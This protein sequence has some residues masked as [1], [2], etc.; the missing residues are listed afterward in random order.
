MSLTEHASREMKIV[1]LY[2]KDAD[3]DGMLATAVEELIRKFAEQ[4][5]SGFSAYQT[6]KIF[7]IVARY[8]RLSPLTNNPDEWAD[9]SGNMGN[10]ACWQSCRQSSCFSEDGGK[11]YYDIDEKQAIWRRILRTISPK[12]SHRFLFKHYKTINRS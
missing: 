2:D 4:G 8:K 3:Y 12:I 10:N 6:L 7:D 9:V 5:H 1:G 11:T